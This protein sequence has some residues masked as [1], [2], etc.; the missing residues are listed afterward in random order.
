MVLET[1]PASP[2][3]PSKSVVAL[4]C[5][6]LTQKIIHPLGHSTA[7]PSVDPISDAEAAQQS[8][9][10]SE[11]AASAKTTWFAYHFAP[12][13]SDVY[14]TRKSTRSPDTELDQALMKSHALID[15][16][17]S[18]ICIIRRSG[19]VVY[20]TRRMSA[21]RLAASVFA[22]PLRGRFRSC[23][24]SRTVWGAG[25]R[26]FGSGSNAANKWRP[27]DSPLIHPSLCRMTSG[28]A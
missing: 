13:R 4:S 18:F 24:S 22:K 21:G 19:N 1:N 5:P 8:S 3:D 27:L 17:V 6:R 9:C 14:S 11:C 26:A 15:R 28:F 10:S 25:A 16:A 23:S 20:L 12:C 7:R 2:D